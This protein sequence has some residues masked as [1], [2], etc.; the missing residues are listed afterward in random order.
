MSTFGDLWR[1]VRLQV[2]AAPALLCQ[3]W[4]QDAYNTLCDRR[5]WVWLRKETQLTVQAAR[6]FTVGVTQGQTAVTSAGLF[7]AGDAGRQFSVGGFPI[8]TVQT[9]TNVN[10]IVLDQ[11]YAGTTNTAAS[12]TISDAFV[13]PP[14]DF[15]R[16]LLIAD[17]PNERL[18][19]WWTTEEE[20]HRVDP[21]RTA[22]GP[23]RLLV[24]RAPSLYTP[25]LG[26][27]QYEW[28]PHPTTAAVYPALYSARP[29][30]LADS[31]SF[32]GVLGGR[33]DV[34]EIG[35]LSRAAQWPGTVGHPNP[36]FNLALARELRAEF[37][38]L[39]IQIDLRDDDQYSQSWSTIPWHRYQTWELAYDTAG[40]RATDATVD[41][42][43]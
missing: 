37:E 35:A 42:F 30:A 32:T 1:A 38:R 18:I 23:P 41:A 9:V 5:G 40:L 25:T 8:Y 16:W 15:G 10:Q 17:P 29:Q 14:A 20:V 33:M 3:R 39:C 11:A 36:Y 27:V 22:V 24:S 43:L 26:R 34:L 12:G 19:P 7:V 21:S 31:H 6:T 13:T 4:G 28:W 2:P